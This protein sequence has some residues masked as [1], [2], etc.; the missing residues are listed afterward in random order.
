MPGVGKN[1]AASGQVTWLGGIKNDSEWIK[2]PEPF[3]Y[4]RMSV[5]KNNL[6]ESLYSIGSAAAGYWNLAELRMYGTVIE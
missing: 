3:R 5:V 4:L 2:A 1:Q 6:D